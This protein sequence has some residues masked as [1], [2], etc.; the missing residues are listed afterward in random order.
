MNCGLT[1]AAEG[2][3][4]LVG[5]HHP[6]LGIHVANGEVLGGECVGVDGPDILEA[7]TERVQQLLEAVGAPPDVQGGE[8]GPEGAE[9]PL[10]PCAF[11]VPLPRALRIHGRPVCIHRAFPL[12]GQK[13]PI[14]PPQP[15]ELRS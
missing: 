10:H 12:T 4:E 13:R 7:E 14:C 15:D 5:D 8:S 9:A 3:V 2:R 11:R 6:L 1:E